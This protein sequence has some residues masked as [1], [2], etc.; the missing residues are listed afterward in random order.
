MS[1]L[2]VAFRIFPIIFAALFP[3]INPVGTALVLYGMTRNVDDQTWRS[4]SRK[5]ALYTFFLL[6]FFF[7]LGGYILKLFGL[8]VP[9]VQFSGG[10][11][12][13][14]IGWKLLNQE[15]ETTATSEKKLENNQTSLESKAFYPYT[16]PIT[17]GPGSLAVV[18]TF[19]AHLGRGSILFTTLEQGCALAGIVAISVVTYVCYANVK[20]MTKKFSP[21]GALALSRILAFFVLAIGVQIAWTGFQAL[22]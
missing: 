22:H 17:V 14:L 21:A 7:F 20:F 11:V 18:L 4:T 3:V 8:S 6:T 13:A 5:I 2:P 1:E 15:E 19:S 16:F 9:V 12:V 10:I